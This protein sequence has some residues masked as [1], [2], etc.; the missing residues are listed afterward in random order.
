MRARLEGRSRREAR[1][2]AEFY[3]QGSD[4]S[5]IVTYN[6][7][8]RRLVKFSKKFDKS[9]CGLE[10]RDVVSFMIWRSK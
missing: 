6:T 2:H 8:F 4:A 7:K 3:L 9:S 10:E 1:E 5:T